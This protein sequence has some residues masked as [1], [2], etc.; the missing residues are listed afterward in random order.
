MYNCLI[1]G[2]GGQGIVLAAKII[3]QMAIDRGEMVR[4]AETI[5]MAQ[6]GGSVFSHIRS[7]EGFFGPLIGPRGADLLIGFEPGETVRCL[8][9]LKPEGKIITNDQPLAPTVKAG[10]YD[11]GVM[12][13]F[14]RNQE[15]DILVLAGKEIV[16]QA[17]STKVLNIALLGAAIGRGFLPYGLDDAKAVIESHF[18]AKLADLNIKALEIGFREGTRRDDE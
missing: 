11:A 2:V 9:L 10:E 8:P 3:A 5:G 12:V 1:V 18:P 7:G 13:D 17:G 16:A 4:T 14:L 15:Q 6:R